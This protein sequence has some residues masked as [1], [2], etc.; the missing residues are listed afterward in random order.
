MHDQLI[1]WLESPSQKDS[2]PQ[3]SE[4]DQLH[5]TRFSTPLYLDPPL[6]Q[7]NTTSHLYERQPL[8]KTTMKRPIAPS[9]TSNRNQQPLFLPDSDGEQVPSVSTRTPLF[10]PEEGEDE[11]PRRKKRR[12]STKTIQ[13]RT[14][15]D[16]WGPTQVS[17]ISFT[18]WS[19]DPS[20]IHKEGTITK[21][22]EFKPISL[23]WAIK[24]TSNVSSPVPETQKAWHTKKVG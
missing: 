14:L 19:Q 6:P 5:T 18:C 24:L 23:S 3:I 15:N 1:T 22:A 12:I 13:P 9:T 20:L 16:L 8:R 21:S 7:S 10:L 2:S 11:R 17:G 4:V